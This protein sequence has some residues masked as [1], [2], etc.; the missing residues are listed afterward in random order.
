MKEKESNRP[1][2]L[3]SHAPPEAE[4]SSLDRDVPWPRRLPR[5][6]MPAGGRG[7]PTQVVDEQLRRDRPPRAVN[8]RPFQTA[9]RAHS[10]PGA[11]DELSSTQLS[12]IGL[13]DGNAGPHKSGS[14]VSFPQRRNPLNRWFRVHLNLESQPA[15]RVFEPGVPPLAHRSGACGSF[16]PKPPPERPHEQ[17]A[18]VLVPGLHRSSRLRPALRNCRCR[19][20]MLPTGRAAPP[21]SD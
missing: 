2:I 6:D 12:S 21:G 9:G 18:R 4:K 8:R 7:R 3:R 20:R 14:I 1:M 5:D 13:R 11:L 19:Q 10:A 16:G 15:F 17:P